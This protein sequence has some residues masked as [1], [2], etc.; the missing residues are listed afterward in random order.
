MYELEIVRRLQNDLNITEKQVITVIGLLNE[1]CTIPFI[2]RYRKEQTN[3]MTDDVLRVFYEKYSSYLNFYD[4]L[5]TILKSIEENYS[6]SLIGNINLQLVRVKVLNKLK[7][8]NLVNENFKD[9]IVSSIMKQAEEICETVCTF[10]NKNYSR[11]RP[12]N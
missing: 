5:N 6:I 4:R 2:A 3:S 9:T 8:S 12:K 10:E 11:Q 1:G 7:E